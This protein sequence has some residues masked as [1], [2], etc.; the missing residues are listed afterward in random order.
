MKN[1]KEYNTFIIHIDDVN[2]IIFNLIKHFS[3]VFTSSKTEIVYE[4]EF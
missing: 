2:Q 1:E 4:L 3:F